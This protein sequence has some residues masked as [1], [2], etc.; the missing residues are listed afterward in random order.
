MMM[1]KIAAAGAASGADVASANIFTA[2]ASVEAAAA[3]PRLRRLPL[4][5]LL[6]LCGF[7]VECRAY[8][9]PAQDRAAR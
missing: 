7:R 6:L 4:L 2:E 3:P 9:A 1:K 8:K 5:L